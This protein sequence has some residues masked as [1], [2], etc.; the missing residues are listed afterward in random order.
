[1]EE[2]ATC[3]L[4]KPGMTEEFNWRGRS[5]GLTWLGE[6]ISPGFEVTGFMSLTDC[7]LSPKKNVDIQLAGN[8]IFF[9]E[10]IV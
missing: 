6:E 3:V 5:R 8:N 7:E 9:Y 4:P 1:M 10:I 2:K